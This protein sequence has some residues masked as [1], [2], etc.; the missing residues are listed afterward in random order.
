VRRGKRLTWEILNIIGTI[1]F[2]V[3]GSI[4][5]MEEEY[6]ILGVYI[7]GFATAFG[8]GV[9]RNLM[10]GIPPS[11]LWKQQDLFML[12]IVVMTLA[13]FMPGLWFKYLKHWMFFDAVGLAAFAIQG[14]MYA[15]RNDF[16][17]SAVVVAAIL[18]GSGGG[19]LRDVLAG[20]KPLIFRDEIYAVWAGLGGLALALGWGHQGWQ[21][22][23]L[24]C[25]IVLLRML[26]VWFGW[27]L[28]KRMVNK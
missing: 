20:R 17:V 11:E 18:T 26:S 27:R 8:G 23:V 12:A 13:F 15:V 28:P 1:A 5:A 4:A 19:V 14:A 22:Y 2:A 6:D 16:P 9:I 10:I 7:L 3:S 24:L 25:V 21:L